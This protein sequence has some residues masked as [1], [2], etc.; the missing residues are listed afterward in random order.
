[1]GLNFL[2]QLPAVPVE[3]KIQ[4]ADYSFRNISNYSFLDLPAHKLASSSV[5]V[6]T[7]L[8]QVLPM[9]SLISLHIQEGVPIVD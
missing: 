5:N 2:K 3:K 1:M 9:G 6:C 8:T 4:A 7:L